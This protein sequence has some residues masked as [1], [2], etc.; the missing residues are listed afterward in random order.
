VVH[1]GPV[2]IGTGELLHPRHFLLLMRVGRARQLQALAR[3]E[4][5]QLFVGLAV[6]LHHAGSELLD[7]VVG[8][9][10]LG[11][12]AALDLRRAARGGLLGEFAV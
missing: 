1:V 9:L 12:L 3:G 5:L 6:V 10:L 2:E 4:L 11:D 8:R 7:L